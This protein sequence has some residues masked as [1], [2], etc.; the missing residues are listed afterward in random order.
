MTREEKISKAAYSQY[1]NS[2]SICFNLMCDSFKQGAKWADENPKS[3]WISVKDDLPCNHKELWM[4]TGGLIYTI[5]TKKVLVV[6]T[7]NTIRVL[8]ML[9]DEVNDKWKWE[10]KDNIIFWM[11]IPELPKEIED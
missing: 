5:Y 6:L 9:Y 3:P 7:D 2:E 4:M 10:F 8:S 11:L 1:C